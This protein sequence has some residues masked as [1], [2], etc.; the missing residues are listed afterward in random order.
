MVIFTAFQKLE[1]NTVFL[2]E[3]WIK[4]WDSTSDANQDHIFE[5]RVIKVCMQGQKYLHCDSGMTTQIGLNI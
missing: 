2:Q 4:I 1:E 5:A 3:S